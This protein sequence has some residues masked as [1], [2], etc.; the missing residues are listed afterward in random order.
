[1]DKKANSDKTAS[2]SKHS[3]YTF[4]ISGSKAD[5]LLSI[6][7]RYNIKE[8]I[9]VRF[10]P[11]SSD[12]SE[13]EK[14]NLAGILE[15]AKIKYTYSADLSSKYKNAKSLMMNS[16]WKNHMFKMYADYMQTPDFINGLNKLIVKLKNYNIL[17]ICNEKLP[18]ECHRYLI[19]DALFI[20]HKVVYH[21][22]DEYTP[23][24]HVLTKFAKVSGLRIFYPAYRTN[25]VT[26]RS[27]VN[28]KTRK[29]DRKPKDR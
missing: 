29:P 13:L 8:V 23:K 15:N 14:D 16:G 5:K 17:I 9:D 20:R 24:K 28:A 26:K 1:M 27:R 12:N 21:L 18:T 2:K 3:I 22:L 19:A 25:K 6:I 4:G 7:H 11:E 10:N